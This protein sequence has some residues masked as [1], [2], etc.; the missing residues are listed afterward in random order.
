MSARPGGS[1]GPK[2]RRLNMGQVFII[3]AVVSAVLTIVVFK[4]LMSNKPQQQVAEKIETR[5]LVVANH[6]LLSGEL[7]GPDSVTVVDW[8]AD[9]Y[10]EGD[11][12][13]SADKLVGKA[14]KSDIF[15]GQPVF[16]P[17][18]AGEDS[19]GGL[20]VVIDPGYRAMTILVSENKGVGGF[21]KPGDRVDVIGTFEFHIPEAS[22]KAL[23]E[24]SGAI[25]LSDGF[26][27]TQTVLQDVKVLAIAQQMYEKKNVLEEGLSTESKEAEDDK[28]EK[29]E[30]K[31][32]DTTPAGDATAGKIVSSVTLAVTP[33]EA[34]K[35]AYADDNGR[36][37]LALRPDNDNEKHHLIGAV[38]GDVLPLSNILEKLVQIATDLDR[39]Y[40]PSGAG[41]EETAAAPSQPEPVS[42]AP[43]SN[44]R[45]VQ[46]IEGTTTSSVSF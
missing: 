12:Y 2:I 1:G 13:D 43:L 31:S 6:Q 8:P 7:I 22:Q 42:S 25:L 37:R 10:P 5:P 38:S 19:D 45:N 18:L 20:P 17:N 4:G 32:K 16:R 46:I 39:S 34:E 36:L 28:G 9:H 33:E 26:D 41:P 40:L 24:K 3:L 27:T 30:A 44:M 11:V 35:L 14:V 29:S 21:I 15:P 23:N